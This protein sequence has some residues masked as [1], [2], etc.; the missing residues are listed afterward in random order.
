VLHDLRYAA[1][2][3]TFHVVEEPLLAVFAG[4]GL[5][6]H[7]ACLIGGE[8]CFASRLACFCDDGILARG[9]LVL[10]VGN[11]CVYGRWG[12]LG[13][14]KGFTVVQAAGG[15]HRRPRISFACL[16]SDITDRS[17]ASYC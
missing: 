6:A 1:L 9:L 5:D 13:S 2:I 3:D 7:F 8:R 15:Q 12:R 14:G 11:E 16:N 17:M 10:E 4:L